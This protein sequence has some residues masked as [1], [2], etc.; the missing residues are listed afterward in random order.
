MKIALCLFKY[1]PY[2]GLQRNFLAIAEEL[3]KRDHDITV[4]TGEWEGDC[5]SDLQLTLLPVKA[6]TNH[7][8]NKQF[9]QLLSSCLQQ[10]PVDVVVGFNKMPGLDIYYCADTCFAAKAYEEKN[11]LYRLSPR[12]CWSIRYERAVFSKTSH[13][14]ILLLSADQ[15][16]A[17]NHYYE[18]PDHRMHLMPP[19][20]S[21][22]RVRSE[23]SD[24]KAAKLRQQLAI[25]SDEK[26]IAFLGSDY[27]RKGLDRL[28]KAVAALPA[29]TLEKTRVLVIGRDKRMKDYE[30]Q[31]VKLGIRDHIIFVGQRDDVPELLFAS[32]CLAHPAYLENTGNVL[33]EAVVAGLPVLCSGVCGYAFY[34]RD[35]NLGAVTPEP[36]K[37]SVMNEQLATLLASDTDWR[38]RCLAFAQSA[39]IY[40]RPL[41]IAEKIEAI[42]AELCQ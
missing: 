18:T 11:W 3:L 30:A 7:G 4:Y 16:K 35:N 41:R 24:L 32:D 20:I 12:S 40:S 34:I 42:G 23:D 2:G 25:A 36:F 38:K 13:T 10:N 33:L 21:R 26:V 14:E 8:R 9:Y 6:S 29:D 31:A 22:T 5:P 1:F 37:Q 39:D 19:G 17:F 27:K 15:G 28:L